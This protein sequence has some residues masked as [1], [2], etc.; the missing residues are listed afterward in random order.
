MQK[1]IFTFDQT[2]PLKRTPGRSALSR[3]ML[4]C[5]TVLVTG[6]IGSAQSAQINGDE[7][8]PLL[9]SHGS[10]GRLEPG[11]ANTRAIAREMADSL[12]GRIEEPEMTP[13]RS[14]FLAKWPAMAGA[15]SYQLDV[16]TSPSF[17]SYVTG[18]KDRD[19]GNTT[20]HIV[21][22]LERGTQYYYR[23]RA[24]DA[25]GADGG[26]SQTIRAATANTSSGLVITPSFD[27][28]ITSDP[29]SAAIQAMII[30]AIQAYQT[31]FSDP[32]TVTIYFRFSGVDPTGKPMDNLVG[33]VTPQSIREIGTPT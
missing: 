17:D 10:R 11:E 30:S 5:A 23:V 14:S 12:A 24:Y 19:I 28:T 8:P 7:S 29:R 2:A 9:G 15:S 20:S 1:S 25:A 32:I 21:S 33:R 16:S 4:I 18:Y 6:Q 3:T 27:S 13:T 22:G 26:T 31:L